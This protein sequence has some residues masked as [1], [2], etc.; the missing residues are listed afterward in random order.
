MMRHMGGRESILRDF[1]C[2]G[3]Q[4]GDSEVTFSIFKSS[5]GG[6]GWKSQNTVIWRG[7]V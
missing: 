6:V 2:Q 4:P 1:I 7:G 3:T 5:W